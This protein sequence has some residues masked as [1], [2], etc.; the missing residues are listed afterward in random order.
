MKAKFNNDEKTVQRYALR[1]YSIGVVSV[2]IGTSI[3]L[4][5]V[6]TPLVYAKERNLAEVEVKNKDIAVK[7][8]YVTESELT[9]NE[10]KS[11]IEFKENDVLA[12]DKT[13]YYFVY[14][15]TEGSSL[16]PKTGEE[17]SNYFLL[18]GA[19]LL[20]I[21]FYVLNGKKKKKVISTIFLVT[22][23]GL[24]T[25][26]NVEAIE[27]NI[28]SKFTETIQL[29]N[30]DTIPSPSKE[31]EGYEFIGYYLPIDISVNDKKNT[32][33]KEIKTEDRNNSLN[34]KDKNNDELSNKGKDSFANKEV[35][36]KEIVKLPYKTEIITDSDLWE[37]EEKI[38]IKG[39]YGQKEIIKTYKTEN[40][41][42]VGNP[43]ITDGNIIP[44]VNEVIRKGTKT[45]KGSTSEVTKEAIKFVTEY[46]DA[47]ELELGKEEVV[48]E[49]KN[50]EKTITTVYETIKEERTDKVLE[51]KEEVTT[52]VVNKVVRK[53]TK[54]V[55]EKHREIVEK[56]IVKVPFEIKYI[57][58]NSIWEGEEVVE[59]N[60]V[61]GEKEIIKTY[62]AENG[63][64]VVELIKQEE[65]KIKAKVDKVVKIGK[66]PVKG[67]I[68]VIT[69]EG[70][71]FNTIVIGDPT[72]EENKEVVKV[73][74][75]KGEKIVITTYETIKGNKTSTIISKKEDIV[76]AAVNREIRRGTKVKIQSEIYAPVAKVQE[77]P[78]SSTSAIDPKQ[79][80]SNIQELPADAVYT[81]KSTEP[82]VDKTSKISKS[83]TVVVTYSDKSFD[84]VPVEIT[85]K[86]DIAPVVEN[87][88]NKQIELKEEITAI[89]L[90]I[91]IDNSG[92]SP[93]I[94]VTNLP[95]GLRYKNGNIIG[96]PT[97]TGKTTVTVEYKDEANNKTTKNF[98]ITVID[99]ASKYVPKANAAIQEVFIGE[100]VNPEAS[101]DKQG[102]VDVKNY[103]WKEGHKPNTAIKGDNISGIVVITYNDDSRDEVN[104][105]VKVK[106]KIVDKVAP[107]IE[108]KTLTK[109]DLDKKITL[110]YNLQDA[111]NTVTSIK[112]QVYNGSA[113][114][115]EVE[116]NKDNLT[117]DI[118]G[119]EYDVDYTLRTITTCDLGEGSK[120][121]TNE[122]KDKVRLELKKLEFKNIADVS[123]YTFNNGIHKK[124]ANTLGDTTDLS[125]YY[126]SLSVNG[127]NLYTPVSSITN[128]NGRLKVT[129]KYENLVEA[130]V[131][132]SSY[133]EDFTFYIGE[134][135]NNQVDYKT[136]NGAKSGYENAYN[137]INK[138]IPLYNK[139]LVI[140]YGNIIPNTSNLYNKIV[141]D[142]IPMKDNEI[143]DTVKNNKQNI[144]KLMVRYLDDTI[145]YFTMTYTT[146]FS[147]LAE[148]NVS[149]NGVNLIYTPVKNIGVAASIVNDVKDQFKSVDFLI[150]EK[151]KE[152]LKPDRIRATDTFMKKL[153]LK[154]KYNKDFTDEEVEEI[155][156][157]EYLE[158]LSVKE[159]FNS[160]K[161][162]IEENLTALLENSAVFLGTNTSINELYKNNLLGDKEKI[163]LGLTYAD[164]LY[165][166][167][168]GDINIGN[169]I[170]YQPKFYSYAK[171]SIEWMKHLGNLSYS[172]ISIKNNL[173]THRQKFNDMTSYKDL[174]TF[175]DYNRELFTDKSENEWFKDSSKAVIVEEKS[176]DNPTA[177]VALYTRLKNSNVPNDKA[178][179]L[180]L[181][182][183]SR[184]SIYV[185]S[186]MSTI[187]YGNIDTY[188]DMT[189][190]EKDPTK[191]KK[192]LDALRAKVQETAIEHRDFTDLLYR[193]SK[194]ENRS[195]LVTNR[196][197]IDT[198][199]EYT[200]DV[201]ARLENVWS[202]EF[203][204]EAAYG[205][206]D[207]MTPFGYWRP[208]MFVG[209]E[210]NGQ[211]VSYFVARILDDTGS[212]VYT[213]EMTHLLD[214]TVLF[215]DNGRREGLGP[216]LF[217]RGIF[218]VAEYQDKDTLFNMNLIFN[219]K[220][221]EGR[222]YNS[223]PERFKTVDDMKTYMSGVFDVIYTLDYAEA[224]G[225]SNKSNEDKIKWYKKIES[226]NTVGTRPRDTNTGT[227]IPTHKCDNFR[228]LT[229]E[230]ASRLNNINSLVD[231]DI[232]ARRYI[233][234]G[235]DE[236]G[237]VRT[238]GYYT[239]DMFKPIYAALFND[240]G[241]SGDISFRRNAYDL[242]AKYGYYEGF[243]P[244]LSNQYKAE[245]NNEGKPLSDE[246]ILKKISN[247]T[248]N[249]MK[250][251]K[252]AV[253]QERVNKTNKLKAVTI[254]YKGQTIEI[255]NFDRIKELMNT[256]ISEDLALLNRSQKATN[257][258]TL[259]QAIYKAYLVQTNDFRDS[260]YQN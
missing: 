76:R 61:D 171:D 88:E 102:L 56:E 187:T 119:L 245:A 156:R 120:N 116:V 77:I 126:T 49:G 8:H 53:G 211:G 104:I 9:D 212:S 144:N 46:I 11:L 255:N 79:S 145:D 180:A 23:I 204:K 10:K 190:S 115:K 62:R 147:G 173:S 31:I 239:V 95:E 162:N 85:F 100:E 191:F 226:V 197:I 37:D 161:N 247:N 72:L 250:E 118:T 216:E 229:D 257:V 135:K 215:N 259:K 244:Y 169:L 43:V 148:Y 223:T 134:N 127:Y 185:I 99:D 149:V 69:K 137:N 228:E 60:G 177:N 159:N 51:K 153:E 167:Q 238:N 6:A 112:A 24:V 87:I 175:L 27:N 86:D 50:G 224:E 193:I 36:E 105:T 3:F 249:D 155:L 30:G 258:D 42:K 78:L 52:K 26:V 188:I 41:Q 222:Y 200:N 47:P 196:I 242:L 233:H 209:A 203:G 22:A 232:V 45:I 48:T 40:E 176:I 111:N 101:I 252:K 183:L 201:Y 205:V 110:T 83:A 34:N 136:I 5:S 231:N 58:D 66:K 1:K 54:V 192:E 206:K 207:F 16:L 93:I 12:K 170:K 128:E 199:K 107:S 236:F 63:Q 248:Y 74:G 178:A 253:I 15:A 133:K 114:L 157:Q 92:I 165:K 213:H 81:W 241:V 168:F 158:K 254:N 124:V 14:R 64:K 89:K 82:S 198:M 28:L 38:D 39:K 7:Y 189:L 75:S 19:S 221:L 65:K 21:G 103:A 2:L 225:M 214:S 174:F 184:E 151:I 166:V 154:K 68:E 172:S 140:K 160:V 138:L 32:N 202:P 17:S 90:P 106:E 129:I 227:S 195:K 125:K 73:E 131:T 217:A 230:E 237:V 218:E 182:N 97:T 251:L 121:I 208:S 243:V 132:D 91:G 35:E 186:T 181:L 59:T 235:I 70:I 67:S 29:T 98:D 146:D 33:N 18:A 71:D 143:V 240:K 122:Y 84:E 260:I 130:N 210:A 164:R 152:M 117:V 194:P 163:L 142:F 220:N 25:K 13:A 113:L 139:E 94:T 55:D 57:E 246:Y 234:Q 4:S 44:A 20:V 141:A 108:V 96:S 109:N 219:S 80:I 179:I 123:L 256:A 150:D